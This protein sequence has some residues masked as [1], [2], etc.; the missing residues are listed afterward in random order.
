MSVML[1]LVQLSIAIAMLAG[2]L[3]IERRMAALVTLQRA[4][5]ETPLQEPDDGLVWRARG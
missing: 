2:A 3:H 5:C 4:T 1:V